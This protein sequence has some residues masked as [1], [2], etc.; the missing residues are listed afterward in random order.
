VVREVTDI[1]FKPGQTT[2]YSVTGIRNAT[3]GPWQLQRVRTETFTAGKDVIRGK[4]AGYFP[5][6][7]HDRRK[8]GSIENRVEWRGFPAEADW[9][10][11]P[12][13]SLNKSTE[14]PRLVRTY[15]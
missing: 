1:R 2:R 4:P 3:Y 14:G 13:T 11:E 12:R 7:L 8:N 5:L 6:A 15:P 9:T 10:W